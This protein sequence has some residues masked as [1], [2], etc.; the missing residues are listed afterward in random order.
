MALRQLFATTISAGGAGVADQRFA[1][2]KSDI[3]RL[4]KAV[5]QSQPDL[6]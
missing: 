5:N 2:V 6:H 1:N 3:A 4:L